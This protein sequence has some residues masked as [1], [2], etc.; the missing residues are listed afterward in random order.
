MTMTTRAAFE[1]GTDSFNAHDMD[2]FAEVV[3]DDVVVLAPG[4]R[5]DGKSAFVEFYGGWLQAFPDAHIE[6][7][8]V[9]FIDD[10]AVEEGTFSGT[11]DGVLRT[12]SGDLPPTGRAARVPYIHVLRY[13]DGLH[14]SFNLV[15]DRL[16]MLE[17]LGLIPVP[18]EVAG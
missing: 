10:V 6:V 11:H 12:P 7:H 5:C 4:V 17:Q 3:A 13:R 18:T 1:R 15:F 8:H 14:A 16:L 2:G 9:H